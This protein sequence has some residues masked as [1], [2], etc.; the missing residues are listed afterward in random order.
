MSKI[1]DAYK[2]LIEGRL[3]RVGYYLRML[4]V[5]FILLFPLIALWGDNQVDSGTWSDILRSFLA[6]M[7]NLSVGSVFIIKRL[8]DLGRPGRDIFKLL[9]P[10]YAF[11]LAAILV[12]K[13]GTTG[14]NQYGPDPLG[15][16]KQVSG[17]SFINSKNGK[18][19]LLIIGAVFGLLMAFFPLP[20]SGNI[21]QASI[22]LG[23]LIGVAVALIELG[24]RR[25]TKITNGYFF[26]L[27]M[28]IVSGFSLVTGKALLAL[29]IGG[30]QIL[31]SHYVFKR[32]HGF[33]RTA[34]GL[35]SGLVVGTV[36]GILATLLGGGA[37]VLR[38]LFAIIIGGGAV[39]LYSLIQDR[40]E[41]RAILDKE[42][43][44]E[45][46]KK[47]RNVILENL[48]VVFSAAFIAV[49]IRV[50][51][52]DNYEIP[53]GSMIPNLLE[54]D[55]LF[56]TKFRYGVRL[57]VLPNWKLPS[58]VEP[59]RGDVIIFQYPL[60]RSPGAFLE[61]MDLFTFSL[62][63]LDPQPKNFV[64]RVIG[65]PGDKV[66]LNADGELFLNGKQ[67]YR[68]FYQRN[69]VKVYWM[70]PRR[71]RRDIYVQNK[72]LYSYTMTIYEPDFRTRSRQ[73][74]KGELLWEE[75]YILYKEGRGKNT[76]IVQYLDK[77]KEYQGSNLLRPYPPG[78]EKPF[79]YEDLA[80]KY[81]AKNMLQSHN[82]R[83]TVAAVKKSN[84]K[85]KDGMNLLIYNDLGEV[86]YRLKKNNKTTPL[87]IKKDG[88]L[89]LV[90][91]KGYYFV[92]GDNRD[93]SA[94]SRIWGLVGKGFIAGSPLLRYWPFKRLG[95]VE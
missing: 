62:F 71:R 58:Y 41:V 35:V 57:P 91:P 31:F 28:I 3:N 55:R 18:N 48:E 25:K 87:F 61:I 51:L 38:L 27:T 7:L 74:R 12:F 95:I 52:I 81:I 89:W 19:A 72:K 68:R 11:Y 53:T 44:E 60:Y 69:R 45:T 67:V 30:L 29:I 70:G 93:M 65:M 86:W 56:V 8:H 47:K 17:D 43:V 9:I 84:V 79:F 40:D 85:G 23:V 88:H 10:I 94:D 6:A 33:I 92:M 39:Y 82:F 54:G 50:F 75:K 37:L 80:D 64:K 42:V 22:A 20:Q 4:L 26:V 1:I 83:S 59:E 63:R 13:K 34:I 32:E 73:Y 15:E 78:P 16:Y 36:F 66:R 24:I 90:V 76:R 14:E 21:I 2:K 49:L 5:L 46:E 77:P